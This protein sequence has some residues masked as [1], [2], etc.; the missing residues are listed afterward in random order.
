VRSVLRRVLAYQN[1]SGA[2]ER[3]ITDAAEA[4]EG[5]GSAGEFALAA[6][7][8][9]QTLWRMGATGTVALEI[10]LNETVEQ[11]M[12]DLEVRA[13]EFL[14]KKEEELARIIDNELTPRRMLEAHLR[15]LPIKLRPRPSGPLLADGKG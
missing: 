12:L 6:T 4:I 10:A 7:G 15:R 2:S 13:L 3:R 11:R 1:I 9:R 14:W 8:R 5:A